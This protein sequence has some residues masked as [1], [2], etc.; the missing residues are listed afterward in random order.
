M[1]FA[2][3]LYP[4]IDAKVEDV[5]RPISQVREVSAKAGLLGIKRNQANMG[6]F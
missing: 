1:C 2:D 3:G 4:L 6:R 5:I